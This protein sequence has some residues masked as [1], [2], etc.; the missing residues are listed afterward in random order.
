MPRMKLV[1]ERV[2]VLGCCTAEAKGPSHLLDWFVDQ[3]QLHKG[4]IVFSCSWH[5]CGPGMNGREL[6]LQPHQAAE[7]R[8]DARTL[9]STGHCRQQ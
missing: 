8:K 5:L 7:T 3:R 9:Y 2:L 4:A 6:L 1:F